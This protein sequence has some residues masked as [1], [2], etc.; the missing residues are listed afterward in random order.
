MKLGTIKDNKVI[1]D[2]NWYNFNSYKEYKLTFF[3]IL[4]SK[5]IILVYVLDV[6]INHYDEYN[7]L[8]LFVIDYDKIFIDYNKFL[9]KKHKYYYICNEIY[10]FYINDTILEFKNNIAKTK[11]IS[12]DLSNKM[13]ITH[14]KK[15]N[16]LKIIQIKYCF[17]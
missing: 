6:S 2:N 4:I 7:N 17:H 13:N 5:N 8:I 15:M 3:N 10:E 1:L 14:K 9:I 11:E 16:N 12:Y